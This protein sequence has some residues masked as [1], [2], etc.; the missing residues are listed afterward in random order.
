MLYICMY[1]CMYVYIYCDSSGSS[2]FIF[3]IWTI[4]RQASQILSAKQ[5]HNYHSLYCSV[6]QCEE[7]K[8]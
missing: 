6:E 7:G 8:H 4:E 3:V 5:S 2:A 1:L